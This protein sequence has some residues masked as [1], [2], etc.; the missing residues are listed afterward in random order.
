MTIRRLV[1]T[2]TKRSCFVLALLSL[3][4]GSTRAHEGQILN[5]KKVSPDQQVEAVEYCKGHYRVRLK[6]GTAHEF[7]SSIYALK[8]TRARTARALA[9]LH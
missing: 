2:A 3:G 7:R 8:P 9:L 5:L 6:D 1:G 4:V